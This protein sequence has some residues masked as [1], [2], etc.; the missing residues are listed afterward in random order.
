MVGERDGSVFLTDRTLLVSDSADMIVATSERLG[1]VL[2]RGAETVSGSYWLTAA[3]DG[4]LL[5]HLWASR[6]TM[7]RDL[8]M[9]SPLA[10]EDEQPVVDIS[11]SGVFAAMAGFGLDPTGSLHSGPA[12]VITYDYSRVPADGPIAAVRD[13]HLNRYRYQDGE[14]PRGVTVVRGG[15]DPPRRWRGLSRRR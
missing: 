9:G 11:G 14:Q 8:T 4:G 6:A 10:S 1:T 12:T 5:R 15:G 3:R 2:G 7:T 13:E